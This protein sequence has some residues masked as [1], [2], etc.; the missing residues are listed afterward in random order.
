MTTTE[1]TRRPL[2]LADEPWPSWVAAFNP[3]PGDTESPPLQLATT[4][5]GTILAV[6][7]PYRVVFDG[8]LYNGD[9]LRRAG[10]APP[11]AND[12]ATVLYAYRALGRE[13]ISRIKGRFALLIW[14]G[15]G[16]ELL[17]A[18]DPLGTY[19][20]FWAERDQEMLFST[21]M[22]ELVRQPGVSNAGAD[23]AYTATG[24]RC[25]CPTRRTGSARTSSSA[26]TSCSTRPSVAA[27][28]RAGQAFF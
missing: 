10:G 15:Q 25:P 5:D 13:V 2:T 8:W 7:G 21:G 6:V 26:S 27:S 11:D 24:I 22:D 19:P 23:A 16:E 12:P 14:D 1:V 20:L 4:G 17:C 9:E 3:R 18:R 28:S